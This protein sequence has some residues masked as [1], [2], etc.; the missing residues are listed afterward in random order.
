MGHL[1]KFEES[2]N[3]S[4]SLS[5]A[6]RYSHA[7]Q[8][9]RM[10]VARFFLENVRRQ[11]LPPSPW[12][13]WS[14]EWATQRWTTG[15]DSYALYSRRGL[16]LFFALVKCPRTAIDCNDFKCSWQFAKDGCSDGPLNHRTWLNDYLPTLRRMLSSPFS[17]SQ[18]RERL[19]VSQ[20][21][22]VDLYIWQTVLLQ[23]S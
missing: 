14:Y 6:A 9:N 13:S 7:C 15:D 23:E 1:T 2:Y 11:F 4:N 5:I 17:T 16:H 20:L 21:G 3:L 12:Q 10:S 22:W 18:A 19:L 8:R